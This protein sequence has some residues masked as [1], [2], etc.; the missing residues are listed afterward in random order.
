MKH[1]YGNFPNGQFENYKVKLHK[2]LFYLLLYKDPKTAE[3]F[4]GVNFD[5]YFVGLMRKIDGLNELLFYPCE[6]VEMM[7]LLE[8]AYKLT[9]DENFQYSIYR[10]LVLDAHN[11]VDRICESGGDYSDNSNEL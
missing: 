3:Q 9:C 11:L 10:K 8:A 2:D 6:I 5:K 4:A 7:G 1:K